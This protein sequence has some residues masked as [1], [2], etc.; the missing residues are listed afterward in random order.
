MP[1]QSLM[2]MMMMFKYPRHHAITIRFSRFHS[3]AT[4]RNSVI[5]RYVQFIQKCVL[6][7]LTERN[8]FQI[9]YNS[10]KGL[11][12]K[13]K[14]IPALVLLSANYLVD[15]F[16]ITCVCVRAYVCVFK[17]Y[18]IRPFIPF[19]TLHLLYSRLVPTSS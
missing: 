12:N 8:L 17:I 13:N 2:F 10:S 11:S 3:R 15:T 6:Q 1:S 16:L 4:N 18:Y 19:T 9:R 14:R 5:H 7:I